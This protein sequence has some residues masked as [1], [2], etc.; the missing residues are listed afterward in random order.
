VSPLGLRTIGPRMRFAINRQ[1]PDRSVRRTI[2]G[3]D[4][5]LPR[6]HGLPCFAAPGSQYAQNLV[7]LA[8]A[9]G[10][11]EGSVCL[12]DVGANIG[13]STLIVLD[14]VRGTAVCVEPDPEWQHYLRINVGAMDN[15]AIEPAVLLAP[16]T[17][18]DAA[19]AIVHETV[20]TSRVERGP[21]GPGPGLPTITTDALLDRYP[22]LSGVRLIKTDTDGYDVMLVPALAKTFLA[23]RPVIFFEFDPRPT[24][25]ATPELDPNGIWDVLVGFGYEHAVVWD[26]NGRLIGPAPTSDLSRRSALLDGSEKERGYGFWD[27]A[28][29]HTDDPVGRRVLETVAAG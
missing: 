25:L 1:L 3:I 29:A 26:N 10:E 27:V 2:R 24:R 11:H 9:L 15:V 28:V 12:L 5:V 7:E 4:F 17:N 14:Q 13:D 16:E 18:E 6:R 20:G 23:S 21:S 8:R 19:L 22:Q